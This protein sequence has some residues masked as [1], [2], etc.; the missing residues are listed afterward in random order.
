MENL[1]ISFNC[2][3]PVFVTMFI[4]HLTHRARI[5]PEETFPQLSRLCFHVL[6]PIMMFTNLYTADFSVSF[7]GKLVFFLV[8]QVV[9]FFLIGYLTALRFVPDP[10]TRGTWTQAFFRSNIAVIGVALAEPMMDHAGVATMTIAI[11][12]I[13][14]LYNVFAVFTLESFRGTEFNLKQVLVNVAKNPLIIGSVLGI[15]FHLLPFRL[16][17]AL[18]SPLVNLGKAGSLLILVALGASFNLESLRGNSRNLA[19]LTFVRLIAAPAFGLI[20]AALSGL[21]GNALGTILICAGTP[22]ATTVFP[23]A[24]AYDSDYELAGELVVVTSLLCCFTMFLWIFLLKQS[25]VM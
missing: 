3:F 21:R 6:L 22:M 2:V 24:Q 4:G 15:I 18:L 11:A 20:L 25:G 10:R 1:L 13:V 16:P 19:F 8:L 9:I 17:G 23:M 7:S 12:I 5:V 14:P